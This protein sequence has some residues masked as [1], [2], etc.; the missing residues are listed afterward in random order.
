MKKVIGGK[1][2]LIFPIIPTFSSAITCEECH[3]EL[4][5]GEEWYKKMN[6]K[7]NGNKK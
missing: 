4:Y 1:L 6:Q 7:W 3:K 5:S 2:S